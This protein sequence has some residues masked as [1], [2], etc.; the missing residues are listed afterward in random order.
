MDHIYYAFTVLMCTVPLNS[1]W[2][3]STIALYGEKNKEHS[4]KLLP[5]RVSKWQNCHYCVWTMHLSPLMLI[6]P[7][8]CLL[9]SWSL[10]LSPLSPLI[11]SDKMLREQ[12]YAGRLIVWQVHI[13]PMF[14]LAG[15]WWFWQ[16]KTVGFL[17]VGLL[18]P[19]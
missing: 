2:Y 17:S 12:T 15:S 8:F 5:L 10:C 16:G 7:L 18:T 1:R 19:G 3:P 13:S 6:Y 11:L 14:G 9:S 4:S